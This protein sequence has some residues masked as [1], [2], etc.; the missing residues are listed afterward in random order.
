MRKRLASDSYTGAFLAPMFTQLCK[1]AMPD[2]DVFNIADDSLIQNTI[3]AGEADACHFATFGRL[4]PIGGRCR[5][6]C[7]HGDLLIG[8]TRHSKRR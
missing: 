7:D 3:A 1:D 6:R 5:R 4:Y 2:V 8:R